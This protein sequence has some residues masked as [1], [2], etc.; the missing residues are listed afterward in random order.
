MKKVLRKV[1][2]SVLCFS[3]IF[4]YSFYAFADDGVDNDV[5][6]STPV[7]AEDISTDASDADISSE[8][9]GEVPSISEDEGLGDS[10]GTEE[11]TEE[12][13]V[14]DEDTADSNQEAIPEEEPQTLTA[15]A[16]DGANVTI[17]ADAGVL[18]EG[19]TVKANAIGFFGKLGMKSAIKEAV[20]ENDAELVE[21][22]AYDITIYS[23]DE[24]VQP[25]GKVSVS[26]TG[27]GLESEGN[28]YHVSD[29]NSVAE[30][31]E[32]SASADEAE[33]TTDHFSIYVVTGEN[34]PALATYVFMNG[35]EKVSTQIVKNGES[36]VEPKVPEKD[37]YKFVGWFNGDKKFTSFG[38]VSVTKT[39]EVT[40]TAS[41]A[42]A[43]YVYFMDRDGQSVAVTKEG[44][45]GDSITTSDVV[46]GNIGADEAVTGWYYDKELNN[47]VES[48]TIGTKNIKVYPKVEKGHWI[49]FET[50][51]GTY[52]APVFYATGDIT[53]KPDDPEKIGYTFDGW[54]DEESHDF[55]FGEKLDSS[56]E[57]VA[58]WTPDDADYTVIY[59]HENADDDNYSYKESASKTGLTGE[60][61]VYDEKS[62]EGFTF[63]RADNVVIAGDGSTIVNVYYSRNEYTVTWGAE[64][65][66]LVCG[67]NE[68]RHNYSCYEYELTC[69]NTKWWHVHDFWCYTKVLKC[70]KEEHSHSSSCYKYDAEYTVTAKHGA[71]IGNKWPGGNWKVKRSDNYQAYL[72]TMPI[73]GMSFTEK[74]DGYG[75]STGIYYVEALDDKD[76]D[77]Y[78]KASCIL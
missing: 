29:D 43:H 23:G 17:E 49:T 22:K 41:F 12:D 33:F 38:N 13:A 58:K 51:G 45:K 20:E 32:G 46:L 16:D 1:L 62:Y 39:E 74:S 26:I 61:A 67:K 6:D 65:K 55:T 76:Y 59:W 75:T 54:I 36:L 48:I 78:Y 27:T 8:E 18:P 28:V 11:G 24:A 47:P 60:R 15:T 37:G 31:V 52:I 9:T 73:G 56:I 71:F 77:E 68:H 42:E 14:T 30:P 3:V 66:K 40:L 64:T 2:V 44:V 19:A 5:T 7:A 10:E 4:S 50:D 53:V 21:F 69:T 34:S 57:L 25:N 35:D 72:E 63:E 70:T